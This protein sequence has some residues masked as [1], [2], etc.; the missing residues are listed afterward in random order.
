MIKNSQILKILVIAAILFSSFFIPISSNNAMTMSFEAKKKEFI[1][2]IPVIAEKFIGTLYQ[3]GGDFEESGVVDNSHLFYLI[4][5]EAARYTGLRWKGYLQMKELLSQSIKIQ[6]ED[7]RNGDLVFLNN[8]H[9]A[10]V[11]KFKKQDNFNL[12][13]SSQ[14]RKQVISFH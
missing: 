5:D 9:A 12:I 7:L 1:N 13:Y 6:R 14:K 4:Y 11:Y 3:Y 8:G 2:R 10:M